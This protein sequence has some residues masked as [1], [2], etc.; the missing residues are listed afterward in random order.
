MVLALMSAAPDPDLPETEKA[1]VG[2]SA[3]TEIRELTV[4]ATGPEPG[5]P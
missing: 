3:L 5:P 4:R 2:G 1:T